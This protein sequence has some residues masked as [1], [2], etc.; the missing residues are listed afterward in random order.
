MAEYEDT[1]TGLSISNSIY[2]ILRQ[3]VEKVFPGLGVFYAALAAIWG[4]GYEVEVGGTFAALTVFG[5]I[6]LSLARRGYTVDPSKPPGGFDGSVVEDSIDGQAVLRVNLSDE[7]A[8]D[9]LNKKQLIIKGYDAS[10]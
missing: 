10:A 7:A 4:W 8:A 2:D 9:L 1:S 3:F 6:L 5:G